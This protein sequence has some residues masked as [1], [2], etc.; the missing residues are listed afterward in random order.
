MPTVEEVSEDIPELYPDTE[1]EADSMES[2]D[3]IEEGD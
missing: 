3:E 2:P 1:D